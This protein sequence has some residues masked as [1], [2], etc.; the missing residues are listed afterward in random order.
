MVVTIAPPLGGGPSEWQFF[1]ILCALPA[2]QGDGPLTFCIVI[3]GSLTDNRS[4]VFLSGGLVCCRS[5][6]DQVT[7]PPQDDCLSDLCSWLGPE[8]GVRRPAGCLHPGGPGSLQALTLQ[9]QNSQTHTWGGQPG[10]RLGHSII[11][12]TYL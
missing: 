12:V 6:P 1:P 3:M 9:L 7:P 4:Y 11:P 2:T 5:S 8:V 10:L